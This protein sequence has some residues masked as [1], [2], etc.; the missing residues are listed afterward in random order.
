[1]ELKNLIVML[2]F[3]LVVAS[4]TS[5]GE[6]I[7][8]DNDAR[9]GGDGSTWDTAFKY[10]QDGLAAVSYG[11]E[12]RVAQGSYI[13]DQNS[14]NLGGTGIREATF[15]LIN[16]VALKG[17]YAGAGEPDPNE[18]DVTANET[19]LS[20]D[21][22]GNDGPDFANNGENSYNVV[23]GSGRI[24]TITYQAVDDSGNVAVARATVTV[25]HDQR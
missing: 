6:I 25:P 5:A 10:L 2:M 18:R 14:A 16:G 17:G 20:G 19:I 15:Q 7:Y 24:Y 4:I 9:V 11:D 21:L 12:I 1:M 8:V 13:P 22:A 23:T 3:L